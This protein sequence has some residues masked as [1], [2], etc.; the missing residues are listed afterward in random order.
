MKITIIVPCYNEELVIEILY[1]RLI[2][3]LSNYNDY[4]IIFI[5]DG[6]N[7]NTEYII[8]KY[9]KE[10]N[11][12]KLFSFSRNFGHQ[13]AV[14]CGILNS[15][16]DIAIIIDADLQDPPELIPSMIDEY[17]KSK[18]NVIYAKRISRE[19][20]NFFKKIT[21]NLYQILNFL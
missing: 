9:R 14:S 19:G 17:I 3:V 6:S 8:D 2:N 21:A 7:D 11:N 16:G 20:E 4:E 15:S 18:S 1:K 13:A 10:N 12:I 5:N